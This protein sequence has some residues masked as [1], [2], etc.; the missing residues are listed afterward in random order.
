MTTSPRSASFPPPLAIS[1][2]A[3]TGAV[4]GA[5]V[6]VRGETELGATLGDLLAVPGPVGAATLLST[7]ADLERFLRAQLVPGSTALGPAIRLSRQ[8]QTA[9]L[10]VRPVGLGWM[11]ATAGTVAWHNGG[12]GGF[13]AI[14]AVADRP[15]CPGGVAI[16][17]NSPHAAALDKLAL[18]TLHHV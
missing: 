4:G 11:L 16:V 7:L 15:R 2:R 3:V 9:D 1:A 5:A 17:V 10:A 13:G 12:T 8:S 14:V 6:L 18:E